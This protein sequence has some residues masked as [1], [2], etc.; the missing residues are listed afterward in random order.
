MKLAKA[1][2]GS[3]HEQC[4][5]G[6]RVVFDL[7]LSNKAW[8]EAERYK[9]LEFLT[10]QSTMHRITEFDLDKSYNK[11]VDSRCIDIMKELK[12]EYSNAIESGNEKLAKELYLKLLYS[13]PAGFEIT[14]SMT[15]N[16]RCL[17]NIYK[18]RKNHRLPEWRALCEQ[19]LKLPLM[20]K[21][22]E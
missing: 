3:G 8:V 18:Q 6:I 20:D 21:L 2:S 12:E 13:N 22:L 10:S 7:K 19:I 11:Y 15:A 4:L 17:I 5:T 1:P 14:A 9:F 16:Y